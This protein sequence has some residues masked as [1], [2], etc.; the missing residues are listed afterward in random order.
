LSEIK[1]NNRDRDCLNL[2]SIA[3]E[4]QKFKNQV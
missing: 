3:L 2:A 4:K 1:R